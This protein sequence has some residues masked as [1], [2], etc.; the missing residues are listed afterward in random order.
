MVQKQLH[1]HD[2]RSFSGIASCAL[3]QPPVHL[4][5]RPSD[6]SRTPLYPTMMESLRVYLPDFEAFLNQKQAAKV[7]RDYFL[8]KSTS[9]HENR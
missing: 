6:W 5:L 8:E 9:L 4:P 1:P 3:W 7:T 2:L